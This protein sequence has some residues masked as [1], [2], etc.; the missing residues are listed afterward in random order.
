MDQALAKKELQ[1]LMKREDLQ[2][3]TCIDCLNPNPQWASSSFAVFLCLQCAGTHRGFGVHISFVRSVSMDTWKEE[4]IRR[5]KLG[6]NAPFRT[7]MR[8]YSPPEQGGYTEGMSVHDKY[9]CWAA[10]QYKEK[11]SA[12]LDGKPW[13]PSPPPPD[14]AS[15]RIGLD[16]PSR[17][18]SAQ[19][20]RKSR[21]SARTATGSSL[22]QNSSS[23]ASFTNSPPQSS[24]MGNSMGGSFTPES[25]KSANESFF[26][27]LGSAN[28]S[29]PADLPPSQG[30]RYQGFGSTPSPSES[31]QHPSYGYSSAS[32]PSLSDFQEN[33]SVAL[34]KGWS[35]FSSVVAGASRV[36]TESVIQPGLERVR[37][38][39]FQ[40][41]LKGYV[42]GAG[43]RVSVV[44][45]SANQWSKQQF[46]VDVADSVGG[47]VDNVKDRVG[48][49]GHEGYGALAT[50]HDGDE[51][52]KYNEGE[53]DFFAEFPNA[54]PS[55]GS[56]S[57]T[58]G[59]SVP[60]SS[61]NSAAPSSA[62]KKTDD[63]DEWKEF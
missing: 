52:D 51:W 4:Q 14:F 44:G 61:A 62:A 37:D 55:A 43:K 50:S 57:R 24:D 45:A 11:L 30:G 10:S 20:L 48:G 19:G 54:R 47:L 63:W 17:P 38:P 46:G 22:R 35:L 3:K 26:A 49:G 31:S 25:Q 27:S 18:S 32:A 53:D 8:N 33:P 23:P 13:S 39:A 56:D 59:S 12:E 29:R 21:T 41:N 2:N 15:P 5:M 9:H 42:D 1:E 16:S 58:A 34:S 40:A 28:A 36:V 7:F 60:E 6:G